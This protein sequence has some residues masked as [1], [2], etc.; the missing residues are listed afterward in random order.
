MRSQSAAPPPRRSTK[1]SAPRANHR[2][3][4]GAWLGPDAVR[5]G[6]DVGLRAPGGTESAR[7][8]EDMTG[9]GESRAAAAVRHGVHT[10]LA[11][12]SRSTSAPPQRA[13]LPL[14]T[15]PAP[16]R[17]GD[18]AGPKSSSREKGA[19]AARGALAAAAGGVASRGAGGADCAGAGGRG[20]TGAALGVAEAG[21]GA[22][23]AS[24]DSPS[25][26]LNSPKS[27][28]RAS[29]PSLR[30]ASGGGAG[31]RATIRCVSATR[32]T[33]TGSSGSGSRPGTGGRL[34]EMGLAMACA[35]VAGLSEGPAVPRGGGTN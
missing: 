14:P 11:T 17:D 32:A 10:P 20:A 6:G 30:S 33:C 34:T 18:S 13:Q 21:T 5:R 3:R 2:R 28:A 4:G 22:A 1:A 9:A 27:S 19:T 31:G 29:G 35:R 12:S 8:R 23:E 25:F 16:G 7:G 26:Q 24:G 15:A